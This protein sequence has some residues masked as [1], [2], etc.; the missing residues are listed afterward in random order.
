MILDQH[1]CLAYGLIQSFIKMR[2]KIYQHFFNRD[3]IRLKEELNLYKEESQIWELKGEITNTSGNLALHLIG[4]LNHFI[5]AIIGKTGFIRQR[6]AEFTTK[7]IARINLLADIDNTIL[8]VNNSLEPLTDEDFEKDYPLEK[9][10]KIVSI[11]HMLIHLIGHLNYH[12][13]QI[14]YHRRLLEN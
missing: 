12:L 7:N 8:I 3:L 14:N 9:N 4:N 2:K 10:E 5:G 13:G 6:P 1:L 11:E